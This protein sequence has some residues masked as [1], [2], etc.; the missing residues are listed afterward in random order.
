MLAGT[1]SER[2][3]PLERRLKDLQRGAL[4]PLR[5][6]APQILNGSQM[7]HLHCQPICDD[8]YAVSQE[9]ETIRNETLQSLD[10]ALLVNLE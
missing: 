8:L 5:E 1:S 10:R 2:S 4:K 6:R 3:G 7:G 9:M